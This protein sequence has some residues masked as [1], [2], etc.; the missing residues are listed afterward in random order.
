M[1]MNIDVKYLHKYLYA[2]QSNVNLTIAHVF[3]HS[4]ATYQKRASYNSSLDTAGSRIAW[5]KEMIKSSL[6]HF[7]QCIQ[8]HYNE[9]SNPGADQELDEKGGEIFPPNFPSNQ[10]D[11]EALPLPGKETKVLRRVFF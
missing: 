4:L 11:L 2:C 8:K 7:W 9:G 6:R 1:E 5:D 10:M 3:I